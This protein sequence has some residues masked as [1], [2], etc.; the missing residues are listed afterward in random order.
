VEIGN[1][2]HPVS[3]PVSSTDKSFIRVA[4]EYSVLKEKSKNGI[5]SVSE[6]ALVN[7]I[8]KANKAAQGTDHEFNYKIHQSTRRVIVQILDKN[9]HEVVR[10][11]P[12]EKFIDLVEKLETL[13]VGAIIDEKR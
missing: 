1:N 13:T 7:A 9:T 4:G 3:T 2:L 8:E 6:K 11:I 12:S 5:L 10:E